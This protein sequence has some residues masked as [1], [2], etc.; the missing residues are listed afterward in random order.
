MLTVV[1]T[2]IRESEGHTRRG[3]VFSLEIKCS[4]VH[5]RCHVKT[6]LIKVPVPCGE[7]RLDRWFPCLTTT[8][9]TNPRIT[10]R[11]GV[12]DYSKVSRV[13]LTTDN[14]VCTIATLLMVAFLL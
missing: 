12:L 10:M 11:E 7:L 14:T 1:F 5:S 13:T 6:M 9:A 4:F 3:C 2:V 8:L